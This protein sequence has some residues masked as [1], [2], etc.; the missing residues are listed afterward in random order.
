M[1]FLA[2]H[3]KKTKLVNLKKRKT[4]GPHKFVFNLL[5]KLDLRS[6][7]K[8]VH[9]NNKRKIITSEWIDEIELPGGSYSA[10]DIQDYIKCILK[11]NKRYP[12]ILLFIFT[13]TGLII[14]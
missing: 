14:D 5:Q 6:L 8:D 3:A 1:N 11:K 13:S 2:E 4:N 9:K 12:L 7:N 10:L